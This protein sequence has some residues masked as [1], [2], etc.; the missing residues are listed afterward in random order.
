MSRN[1]FDQ[2]SRYAAKLEPAD[3]LAW[4]LGVPALPL[5]F[6]GWLDTRTLPFPGDPERTCDTVAC[7]AGPGEAP[8]AIALEFSL[9]PDAT[10]F[11]RLLVYLGQLWLEQRPGQDQTGR[12]QISATVVN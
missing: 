3:F 4:L 6:A 11:G 12:N 8:W 1:R 2:A 5:P 10:L 7:L 9:A